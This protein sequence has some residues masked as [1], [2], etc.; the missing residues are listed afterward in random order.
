MALAGLIAA[1]ALALP[2]VVV[3][4][5]RAMGPPTYQWDA[6]ART[7]PFLNHFGAST[8]RQ[9]SFDDP[10]RLTKW[11]ALGEYRY[12]GRMQPLGKDAPATQ[13]GGERD[14]PEARERLRGRGLL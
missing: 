4:A 12:M 8:Y 10:E 6:D 5:R 3:P 13:P 1:G 2:Y 9:H 11:G 7:H 14:F